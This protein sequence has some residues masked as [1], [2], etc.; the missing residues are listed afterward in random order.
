MRGILASL[1]SA[2]CLM[3]GISYRRPKLRAIALVATLTTARP[4]L[5]VSTPA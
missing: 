3:L 4:V 1:I 2:L 5:A